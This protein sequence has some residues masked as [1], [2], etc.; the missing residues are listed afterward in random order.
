M[1]RLPPQTLEPA[2]AAAALAAQ[3]QRRWT[4]IAAV[5]KHGVVGLAFGAAIALLLIGAGAVLMLSVVLGFCT[6]D[7][8]MLVVGVY[9]GWCYAVAPIAGAAAFTCGV[10]GSLIHGRFQHRDGWRS[11]VPSNKPQEAASREASNRES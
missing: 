3:G 6:T 9:S 2:S 1:S 10:L 11:I 4:G 5:L 8:D 7:T